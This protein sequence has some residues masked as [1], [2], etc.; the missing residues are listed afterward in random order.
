MKWMLIL[1][2]R[3]FYDA[4]STNEFILHQDDDNSLYLLTCL[5]TAEKPVEYNWKLREFI[6]KDKN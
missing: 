4:V 6:R 3:I 2:F 5:K 1:S